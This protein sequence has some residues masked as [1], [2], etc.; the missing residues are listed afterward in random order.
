LAGGGTVWQAANTNKV[1]DASNAPGRRNDGFRI[2][3]RF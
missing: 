1:R 2:I 3:R